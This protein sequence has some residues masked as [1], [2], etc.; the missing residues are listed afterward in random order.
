MSRLYIT[1]YN[2]ATLQFNCNR[3]GGHIL[4]GNGNCD[5][6]G[7][8]PSAAASDPDLPFNSLLMDLTAHAPSRVLIPSGQEDASKVQYRT[9]T[10][11]RG[12][13]GKQSSTLNICRQLDNTRTPLLSHHPHCG[14]LMHTWTLILDT[15]HLKEQSSAM[16]SLE[17]HNHMLTLTLDTG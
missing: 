1:F 13:P 10:G 17:H 3:Y 5:A 16:W 12:R 4:T 9:P 7:K 15:I 2:A 11:R 14:H 6:T 8:Q